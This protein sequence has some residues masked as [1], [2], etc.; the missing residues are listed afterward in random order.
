MILTKRRER[1]IVVGKRVLCLNDL[2]FARSKAELCRNRIRF[3]N[4]MPQTSKRSDLEAAA[5]VDVV[6]TAIAAMATSLTVHGQGGVPT[7]AASVH[8]IQSDRTSCA[9]SPYCHHSWLGV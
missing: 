1:I 6:A 5:R 2:I 7:P 3:R 4:V 9:D 8:P